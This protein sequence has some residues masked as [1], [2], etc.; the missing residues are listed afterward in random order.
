MEGVLVLRCVLAAVFLAAGIAKFAD[1]PGEQKALE[2]FG[3][4]RPL[5]ESLSVALPLVEVLV[6]ASL[7]LSPLAWWGAMGACVLLVA[8]TTV[9]GLQLLSGKRPHCH[10]F[11]KLHSSPLG[12]TTLVRNG[13][14][15]V[16]T[17]FVLAQGSAR[18]AD[19]SMLDL[20]SLLGSLVSALV[21]TSLLHSLAF[22]LLLQSLSI[23]GL[24]LVV[25]YLIR[26]GSKVVPPMQLVALK[27]HG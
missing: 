13:L 11:G 12:A 21:S 3:V 17:L 20:F 22:M 4:P 9:I 23:S 16:G 24:L 8:F 25:F 1:R 19:G 14:L 26:E 2:E 15:I 18:V 6:G 10:C 5:T 27:P 7:L